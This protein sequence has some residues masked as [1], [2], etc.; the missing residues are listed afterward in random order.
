MDIYTLK[1]VTD[2]AMDGTFYESEL[3][4]VKEETTFHIE[5]VLK[6]EKNEVLV[7][8]WGWPKKFNSGFQNK[9][10]ISTV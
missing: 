6:Q 2:D 7:N 5:K 4:K 3:S 8:W 9:T 10:C 1:D